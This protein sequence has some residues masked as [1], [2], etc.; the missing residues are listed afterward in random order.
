LCGKELHQIFAL[1]KAGESWKRLRC[2][3]CVATDLIGNLK[4]LGHCDSFSILYY[5]NAFLVFLFCY[6]ATLTPLVSF[7]FSS[8]LSYLASFTC[9]QCMPQCW[10]LSWVACFHFAKLHCFNPP[11]FYS[12]LREE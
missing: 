7:A 11:P 6:I 2:K 5:S 3:W 1:Y 8:I 4:K 12:V 9:S 10:F